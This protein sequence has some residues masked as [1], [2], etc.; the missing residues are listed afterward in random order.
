MQPF[1]QPAQNA[2]ATKTAEHRSPSPPAQNLRPKP[3]SLTNGNVEENNENVEPEKPVRICAFVQGGTD[4][5]VYVDMCI[6]LHL[7]GC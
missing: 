7:L 4:F 1:F 3:I 6:G 5:R 2:V